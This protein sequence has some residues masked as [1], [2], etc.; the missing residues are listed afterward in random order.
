MSAYPTASDPT[1]VS[2][3]RIGSYVVDWLIFVTLIPAAVFFL[4]ADLTQFEDG[5]RCGQ[6]E[7]AGVIDSGYSCVRTE[8]TTTDDG[9]ESTSYDTFVW[10][11]SANVLA[12]ATSL[13]YLVVVMWI[14]QGLTGATVGKLIFG[15]R[16]INEQ[17]GPP[18][19]GRQI[20]RGIGGIVDALPFCLMPLVPL[21]GLITMLATK[22]HRRVCD[23]LARTY[24]VQAAAAGSPLAGDGPVTGWTTPPTSPP[25]PTAAGYAAPPTAPSYGES[26]PTPAPA[27]AT[28]PES[29]PAPEASPAPETST[30]E[31][32]PD[33]TATPA[34][35]PA[36]PQ[37]D[38]RR[39]AY[40]QWDDARQAW[41]VYD[42]AAGQWKPL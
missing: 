23:M 7:R 41:F 6:L 8:V 4:T 35:A 40:V 18:G 28:A 26:P 19:L 3:R 17:G 27:P 10:K 12:G 31:P 39:N 38:P 16:T 13:A 37:W 9:E 11:N 20:L 34:A 42:D 29:P 2:G 30:P 32:A 21:V 14:L 36:G 5:P 1:A 22:K 24:V 25:E 33:Q 15:I